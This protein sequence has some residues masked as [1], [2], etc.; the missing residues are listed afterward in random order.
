M[1]MDLNILVIFDEN[2]K[3]FLADGIAN[4]IIARLQ[5]T[6]A[7]RVTVCTDDPKYKYIPGVKVPVI[8]RDVIIENIE[9]KHIEKALSGLLSGYKEYSNLRVKI[10]E[11]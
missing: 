10:I 8:L 5:G 9:E 2:P 4:E 1:N 11:N 7:N 3:G 6:I